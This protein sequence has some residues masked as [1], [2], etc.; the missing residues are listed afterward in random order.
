MAEIQLQPVR[1][2]T[3]FSELSKIK[4]LFSDILARSSYMNEVPI[5]DESTLIE[6]AQKYF[7]AHNKLFETLSK[8]PID[9]TSETTLG[10]LQTNFLFGSSE[11]SELRLMFF[12]LKP[13][14]LGGDRYE[15][16][17]YTA[18]Q[19]PKNVR[20]SFAI[21]R[22]TGEYPN[23][24][25]TEYREPS[26]GFVDGVAY[27]PKLEE[28]VFSTY[29]DVFKKLKY[30]TSKPVAEL[31]KEV[32]QRDDAI[33]ESLVLGYSLG[34]AIFFNLS[35]YPVPNDDRAILFWNN[36]KKLLNNDQLKAIRELNTSFAQGETYEDFAKGIGL[37]TDYFVRFKQAWID[38]GMSVSLD[39]ARKIFFDPDIYEQ[40]KDMF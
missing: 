37:Q 8:G 30:D 1:P 11:A 16:R 36:L 21:I 34:D 19:V 27:D 32:F 15:Y 5:P 12:G 10:D 33:S 28:R 39:H 38:S 40:M 24:E 13:A 14:V 29:S 2:Q 35:D 20:G 23:I 31:V 22:A 7:R 3:K 4:D 17:N 18:G 9:E 6:D 25:F 26:E